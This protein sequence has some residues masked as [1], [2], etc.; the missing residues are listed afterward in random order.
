MTCEACGC[1]LDP[2]E[3]EELFDDAHEH[4]TRL[5]CPECGHVQLLERKYILTL[6][7]SD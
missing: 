1:H 2:D 3:D 4:G 5:L 7:D 6:E